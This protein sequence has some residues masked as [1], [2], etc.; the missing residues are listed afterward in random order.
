MDEL[1][2]KL[3]DKNYV[4]AFG[5]MSK[6]EQECL[7]KAGKSNCFVFDGRSW[8]S[9][10]YYSDK[11]F[12]TGCT[13]AIKPDYKPEPEF[14]DLEIDEDIE[15]STGIRWLGVHKDEKSSFLP[16]LF[17]HLHCLPSLPN[18]ERFHEN[19]DDEDDFLS[20]EWIATNIDEGKKV[21][22]RFRSRN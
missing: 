13:Y 3:K 22:A 20:I 2:E 7:E 15:I 16:Y 18:F 1:I 12:H 14:V 10:D 21:V 8:F 4:R 11:R 6:E 17:T 19:D 5:L 9:M